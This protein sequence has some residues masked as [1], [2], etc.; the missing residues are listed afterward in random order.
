MQCPQYK[1]ILNW[2]GGDAFA[3]GEA[4][5]SK[6]QFTDLL[7]GGLADTAVD[8]VFYCAAAATALY[9]SDVLE[10]AGQS[11]LEDKG[12]LENVARW[13][14]LANV[15]AMVA[16]GEDPNASAIEGAR[17]RGLGIFFSL[18]M[19][20][21]HQ[22]PCD[23][24]RLKRDHP[25]WLLG[26]SVPAWYSDC[27]DYSI[28]EVR[29]HRLAAIKELAERWD[30][31]GI[32]LDWQRHSHH[33]PAQHAYRLRYI[34][35]DFMAQARA[36]VLEAGRKRGRPLWLAVRVAADEHGC[37]LSGYDVQRWLAAGL[38]DYCIPSAVYEME[39]NLDGQWWVQAAAAA[40][41]AAGAPAVRIY[42]SLGGEFFNSTTFTSS[43]P[44]SQLVWA[45]WIYRTS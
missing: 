11:E 3:M 7:F 24:P 5:M 2:D 30:W 33:L 8:C 37:R 32:E 31:D 13:R 27:W 40:T 12:R 43:V 17:E 45:V 38:M 15:Q 26:D 1:V 22:D 44:V 9:P 20:D 16:R 25:E 18:R 39:P 42:P 6:A 14:A 4:G 28:A 21:A 10:L 23:W 35:T 29:E 36:I 41:T 19:N 34:L